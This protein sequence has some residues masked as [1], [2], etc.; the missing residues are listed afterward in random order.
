MQNGALMQLVPFVAVAVIFY[1][2]LIRPQQKQLKETK[3]MLDALKP[4]DK[5]ITRGGMIGVITAVKDDEVEVEIAKG[6]KAAFTRSAVG[7]VLN[8]VK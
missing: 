2:L 7:A 4:G 3:I 1:F 8:A 6:I 5:V